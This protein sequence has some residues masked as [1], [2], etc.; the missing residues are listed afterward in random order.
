MKSAKQPKTARR[1][2]TLAALK[3]ATMLATVILTLA[4][5]LCRGESLIEAKR[6]ATGLARPVFVAAP[7]G[8][9]DELYVLEQHTARIKRINPVTG[10]MDPMPI[11]DLSDVSTGNEQGLLGLAFDPD[12]ASNRQ[13]YVNYTNRRG[14]TV[15]ESYRLSP[16]TNIADPTTARQILTI[17]QP[18]GNHNAGW[19]DFGPRDGLLYIATGDGGGANDSGNGH[20]PGMG[21]AQDTMNNLLG[22]ML[23]IDVRRDDFPNDQERNYAIPTSNPFVGQPGDDEIWAFGL[24]NPWRASFDR[25]TNDLYIADVGQNAREEIDF[26]RADSAGGENYGWRLREGLIATPG[27]GGPRPPGNIDPI[28]DYPHTGG[29]DGGFSVTGGY[30]YRGPIESLQGEYFFADFV[31]NQIWTLKHDG[32]TAS[33]VVNRTSQIVT[34]S[35]NLEQ[36]SSFG[37]DHAGNLYV[38][39]LAGDLFRIQD[40]VEL[41]TLVEAGSVW[42][43]LD[44]GSD[45]GSAWRAIDFDDSN[46]KQGPA[47]LGYGDRDEATVVDFG[48]DSQNRFI[49]TYFRKDFQ[50][51]DA[52][53]INELS[54]ELLRDDGAAVYLNGEELFRTD[55]LAPDAAFDTLANYQGA[56]PISGGAEDEFLRAR[57]P[58]DAIR[59][60]RNVLAVEMHQHSPSSNDLS[61]DLRLDAV[62]Q[63]IGDFNRNGSLDVNDIDQLAQQIRAGGFVARFDMNLDQQIGIGDL[64]TWV[65]NMKRTW[66]GDADL[67]GVFDEADLLAVFQA[68]EYE[69]AIADNS[70]WSEGD[71]NADGDFTTTDLLRAFEDGGYRAGMRM[72]AAAVPEPTHLALLLVA[73][74]VWGSRYQRRCANR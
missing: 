47:Q 22:K 28:H 14:D 37:E 11:L 63:A 66:L 5:P 43:Y 61:F 39:S 45:Q 19:M 32:Q 67:N 35:G 52:R 1:P 9:A 2:M 10:Q 15:V 74:A 48:P 36:I 12:F 34:D 24:R 29:P 26:Q 18:Q 6:L 46:W 25:Q 33:E 23:R 68:G 65:A 4:C 27:V 50:V 20:T 55:N 3:Q 54:L 71:W 51:D 13:F 64:Q 58:A 72:E 31:T 41:T 56:R 69:D 53:T 57:L 42:R 30:V 7:P 44:D 49:T 21:N 17:D 73:A 70:T 38:V 60:G 59:A 62:I 16:E 8:I 40:V